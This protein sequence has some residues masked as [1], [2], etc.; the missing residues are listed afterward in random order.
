MAVPSQQD[1]LA[2]LDF[3]LQRHPMVQDQTQIARDYIL[4]TSN[5]YEPA[6]DPTGNNAADATQITNTLP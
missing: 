1:A 4:S 3:I 6:A 2:A 5:A